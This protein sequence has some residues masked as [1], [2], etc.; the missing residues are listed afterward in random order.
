MFTYYTLHSHISIWIENSNIVRNLLFHENDE[1][2]ISA[3]Q[4][5]VQYFEKIAQASFGDLRIAIRSNSTSALM[6][7]TTN[8]VLEPPDDKELRLMCHHTL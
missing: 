2:K 6:L 7:S 4:R 1:I 5:L 8:D 3:Q